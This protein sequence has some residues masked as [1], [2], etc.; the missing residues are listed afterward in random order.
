MS[1]QKLYG[2][3]LIKAKQILDYMITT[4]EAQN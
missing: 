4:E 2:S 1:E 3:S